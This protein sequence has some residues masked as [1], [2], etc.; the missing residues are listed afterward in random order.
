MPIIKPVIALDKHTNPALVAGE[1][2][3]I[4]HAEGSYASYVG[5]YFVPVAGGD[6]TIQYLGTT[7][8][9]AGYDSRDVLR[10]Y[11]VKYQAVNLQE[12]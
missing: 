5:T 10:R 4:L 9:G 11:K 12:V 1:V 8:L 6:N 3:R 2:F 7:A